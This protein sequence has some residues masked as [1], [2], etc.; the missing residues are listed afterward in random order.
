MESISPS[1]TPYPAL[2]A[3]LKQFVAQVETTLGE[4]LVAAYLLGSFA[5]GDFDEY[6]DVDFLVVTEHEV[7]GAEV[8][9][10]QEM[11]ARVHEI[12][13]EWAR[14]LEGSYFP[15]AILNDPAAVG[16]KK[17]WYLDNGSKTLVLSLHDNRWVDRWVASHCGITLYGPLPSMLFAPVPSDAL[18]REVAQTMRE[19]G[20]KL[21][22]NPVQINSCWYQSFVVVQYCRML[23]TVA[24]GEVSSKK[25]EVV[26]ALAHLD[27]AWSNLIRRAWEDRPDPSA[28]GR[29]P[30][31]P[32][33]LNATPKFVRFAIDKISTEQTAVA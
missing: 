18:K 17:L 9:A 23:H 26:W 7:S 29:M 31:N 6:S 1:P 11:H 15:R 28:K 4:N 12:E 5:T 30:A 19:W 8:T 25:A 13:S 21:L 24:S 33:L 2:N 14:H 16:V 3:V 20:N 10:L 27:P 22:N 32:E